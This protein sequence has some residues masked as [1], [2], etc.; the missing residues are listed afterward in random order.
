[1]S[2]AASHAWALMYRVMLIKREV[3]DFQGE[4]SAIFF[5]ITASLRSR[6]E[7]RPSA[8]AISINFYLEKCLDCGKLQAEASLK[9]TATR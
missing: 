4:C 8:C 6:R 1:M 3:G 7:C 2:T 9:V 5:S